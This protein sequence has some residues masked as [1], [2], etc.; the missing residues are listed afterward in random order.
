MPHRQFR[1]KSWE[2]IVCC[3]NS[4]T[5]GSDRPSPVAALTGLLMSLAVVQVGALEEISYVSPFLSSFLLFLI[6]N[7]D[8]CPSSSNLEFIVQL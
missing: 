6:G 5:A 7:S 8:L 4:V 2:A 3:L 1:M